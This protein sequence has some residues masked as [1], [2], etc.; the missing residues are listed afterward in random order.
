MSHTTLKIDTI[1]T[2][3][4]PILAVRVNSLNTLRAHLLFIFIIQIY[5]QY[6]T[7]KKKN[8]VVCMAKQEEAINLWFMLSSLRNVWRSEH[9]GLLHNKFKPKIAYTSWVIIDTDNM[10]LRVIKQLLCTNI[11]SNT[12]GVDT[13]KCFIYF[14]R[15]GHHIV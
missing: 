2:N 5:P 10:K 11:T 15:L 6:E 9:I 14:I 8:I 1:A 13:L 3:I 4:L 12:P 7:K